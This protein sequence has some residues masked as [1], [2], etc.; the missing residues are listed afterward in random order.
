MKRILFRFAHHKSTSGARFRAEVVCG[1]RPADGN[2]LPCA[3]RIAEKMVHSVIAQK[4]VSV[5]VIRK[6]DALHP[7]IEER[8]IEARDGF[9]VLHPPKPYS[10]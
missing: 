1:R 2:T 4:V 8:G 5:A 6:E 7:E 9:R 10:K 3:V